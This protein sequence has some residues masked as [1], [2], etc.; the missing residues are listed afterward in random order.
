MLPALRPGDWVIV[1]REAYREAG[2]RRRQIALALDPRD[3]ARTL[4]KRVAG[5][6]ARGGVRLLGDNP[7]ASTDSRT[8][9][10]F[11]PALLLG[12]VRWRYW[13]PPVGA[14]R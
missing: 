9:G 2:A 4:V 13:P 6:E 10:A 5:V 8:L 12:R 3:E 14:V 1:D 11:P 7:A